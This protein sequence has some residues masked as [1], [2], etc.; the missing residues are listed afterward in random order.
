[1]S[2]AADRAFLLSG[3]LSHLSHELLRPGPAAGEV[4]R[5]LLRLLNS[6]RPDS[7]FLPAIWAFV[8]LTDTDRL[9]HILTEVRRGRWMR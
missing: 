5:R 7:D 4:R 9:P 3:R 6:P 8:L 1:M 2:P